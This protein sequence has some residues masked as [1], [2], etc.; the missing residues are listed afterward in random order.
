[1]NGADPF[2]YR[3]I[4]WPLLVVA[5]AVTMGMA[6]LAAAWWAHRQASRIG[7][8]PPVSV[9]AP[10][11]SAAPLALAAPPSA[12]HLSDLRALFKLAA[13]KRLAM[14]SVDYQSELNPPAGVLVRHVV[15]HVDDEYPK[16]KGFIAQW[17]RATPHSQL[18]EI[19][20]EQAAGPQ[21]VQRIQATIKLAL[22]YRAEE[23]G[24]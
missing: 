16:V 21:P 19:Q 15:L 14:A 6:M 10:I 2:A 18:E 8:A 5:L 3:P 7:T 22:V 17:L 23:A 24:P 9:A 20:I 11:A 1:M 13:E 12:M 4:R